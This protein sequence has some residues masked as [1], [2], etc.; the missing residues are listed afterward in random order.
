MA[1]EI[2]KS[3]KERTA[4]DSILLFSFGAAQFGGRF[5]HLIYCSSLLLAAAKDCLLQLAVVAVLPS[6]QVSRRVVRY[7]SILLLSLNR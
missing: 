4:L 7:Q 5:G 1:S 3:F 6:G 2:V